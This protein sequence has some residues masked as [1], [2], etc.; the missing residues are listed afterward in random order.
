M[1]AQLV[2]ARRRHRHGEGFAHIDSMTF[3][4]RL[5]L[6]QQRRPHIDTES[7]N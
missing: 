6:I 7:W 3:V 5:P 2:E 4:I 1:V